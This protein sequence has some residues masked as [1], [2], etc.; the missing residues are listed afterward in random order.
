MLVKYMSYTRALKTIHLQPTDRV[1][2]QETLDGVGKGKLRYD[3][4]GNKTL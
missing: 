1:A 2:Q 4:I 3:A